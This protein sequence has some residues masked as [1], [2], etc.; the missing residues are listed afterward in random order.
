VR[1]GRGLSICAPQ[2]ASAAVFDPA[3]LNLSG[4]WRADFAASPWAGTASAGASGGRN[5]STP[6]VD[7]T[8]GAAQNGKTPAS[9]NGTSSL[10]TTATA[11]SD[12]LTVGA[13]TV[14]VVAYMPTAAVRVG[15]GTD[16]GMLGDGTGNFALGFSDAGVEAFIFDGASKAVTVAC[17]AAAYHL[18]E[19]SWSGT[20]LSLAIDSGARSSVACGNVL[21]LAAAINV[22]RNMVSGAYLEMRILDLATSTVQLSDANRASFKSYANSRYGLAL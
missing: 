14:Y 22:G 3:T 13:G 21:S 10:L 9:F 18:I 1:L 5:L 12:F 4:W 17:S 7:P 15:V 8:T 16:P 20:N 6:S 2:P 11:S 19:M